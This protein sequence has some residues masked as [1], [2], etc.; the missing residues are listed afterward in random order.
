MHDAQL[1]KLPSQRCST[2][3]APDGAGYGKNSDRRET[4]A[5]TSSMPV[6][7]TGEPPCYFGNLRRGFRLTTPFG[8]E[9]ITRLCER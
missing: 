9:Q 5:A 6:F 2:A 8:W 3:L 1:A 7:G 4:V